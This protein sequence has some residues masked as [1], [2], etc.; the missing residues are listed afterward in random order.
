V[1]INVE[2]YGNVVVLKFKGEFNL[3][4]IQY[5]ELIWNEQIT[6]KPEI[7]ALNF[8]YLD[9][10]DSSA[11]GTLVKFSN[12]LGRM[13]TRMVFV[14]LNDAIFEIFKTTKLDGIFEIYSKENF[15]NTI[16]VKS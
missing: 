10:I 2:E 7:I 16:L 14:D 4:N 5:V 11:I 12:I 8:K 9:F 1:D 6:K 15:E 13:A 3:E